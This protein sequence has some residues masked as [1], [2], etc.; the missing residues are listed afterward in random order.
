M[1]PRQGA[2]SISSI[3]TVLNRTEPD[4]SPSRESTCALGKLSAQAEYTIVTRIYERIHQIEFE[5]TDRQFDVLQRAFA[6]VRQES[7]QE[8]TDDECLM[9]D[10]ERI[11]EAA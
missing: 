3:A 9:T 8:L 11:A 10:F 6:V 4:Q 7:G 1:S 2:C 5:F